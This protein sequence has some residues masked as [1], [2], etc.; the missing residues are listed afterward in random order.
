[1]P[2]V[3]EAI[4]NVKP[5]PMWVKGQTYTTQQDLNIRQEPSADSDTVPYN[6]LTEDAKKHAFIG[7]SGN[8]I[9]KRGT[10]VTVKDIKKVGASTWLRIPSGWVC[11][12]NS[13]NTYVL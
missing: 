12:C 5:S 8:T 7:P 1:L 13:K 2:E 3:Y 11:G 6:D 10:R 9:L 4:G